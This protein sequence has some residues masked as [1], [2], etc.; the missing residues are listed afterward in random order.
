VPGQGRAFN[1]HRKLPHAREHVEAL[2]VV[3]VRA[4]G[5]VQFVVVLG[6]E[7]VEGV[8]QPMR[9]RHAPA[10][11]HLG[12]HRGRG[13]R[14]GA[15]APFE[16]GVPDDTAV[17]HHEVDGQRVATDGVVAVGPA[18]RRLQFMVVPRIFPVVQDHLLIELAQ[19]V[20]H[21]PKIS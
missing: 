17:V 5:S 3:R 8:E 7:T 19:L 10:L 11:E 15:A 1:A 14:D 6:A 13:H 18:G 2:Q 20:E 21:Y 9:V 16:R 12:H 4:V